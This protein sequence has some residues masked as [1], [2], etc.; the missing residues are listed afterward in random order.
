MKKPKKIYWWLICFLSILINFIIQKWP[1]KSMKVTFCDVGQGDS[2]LIQQDFFQIMIDSGKDER[3]LGCLGQILPVW[4]R[5]IEVIIITHGDEDHLGFFGEIMGIYDTNFIFFPDTTKDTAVIERVKEAIEHKQALGALLKQP[6]LG[7]SISF[8]SGG[9]LTFLKLP[10]QKSEQVDENDQSIVF[11]L[12][13]GETRWLFTGDLGANGELKLV[14]SGLLPRVNVLKVAHH[15]SDSSSNLDFLT[16]I[17]PDLSIISVGADNKYG[18][19]T[20]TVLENLN[21]IGSVILRTDQLG[22][23]TLTANETKI[24]V[25]RTHQRE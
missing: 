14:K 21:K 8:P 10:D 24:W 22:D 6:I 15:G 4:D 17:Q 19:P 16:T 23:I 9:A 7:Q 12:E 2:I 1:D 11:L 25:S 13:Y 20:T 3:V 18:H 5:T